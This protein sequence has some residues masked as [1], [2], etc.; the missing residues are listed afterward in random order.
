MSNTLTIKISGCKY[1]VMVQVKINPAGGSKHVITSSWAISH[2]KME[3]ILTFWKISL[4]PSTGTAVV[5]NTVVRVVSIHT[6]GTSGQVSL[7]RGRQP[8]DQWVQSGVHSPYT[9]KIN[10]PSQMKNFHH[11]FSC[12]Y[13]SSAVHGLS[14]CLSV[15]L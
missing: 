11:L 9:T 12:V 6:V 4:F 5:G 7:P 14:P 13:T 10:V 15:M 2:V 8:V 1:S 3:W